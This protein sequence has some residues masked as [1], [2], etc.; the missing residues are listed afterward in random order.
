MMF[1]IGNGKYAQ[2]VTYWENE[3][4]NAN[5]K[6]K[7]LPQLTPDPAWHVIDYVITYRNGGRRSS[8]DASLV[9]S[10]RD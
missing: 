9:R 4:P 2:E 8:A 10:P 5:C 3:S 1:N 7:L 6:L